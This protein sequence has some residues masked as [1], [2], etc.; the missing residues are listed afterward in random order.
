MGKPLGLGFPRGLA[1]CHTHHV[2]L[3]S[4]LTKGGAFNL[5]L[6]QKFPVKELPLP[7]R[8]PNS[9]ERDGKL[10]KPPPQRRHPRSQAPFAKSRSIFP[11]GRRR[12][13]W[14]GEP[15]G[16]TSERWTLPALRAL[17][18]RGDLALI[19]SRLGS[20]RQEML[21]ASGPRSAFSS[22][23]RPFAGASGA[24]SS[25]SLPCP[26]P[27]TNRETPQRD[28]AER[29]PEL[30]FTCGQGGGERL[31]WPD[32]PPWV[33]SA[34]PSLTQGQAP[35][36]KWQACQSPPF[37]SPMSSSPWPSIGRWPWWLP[38]SMVPGSSSSSFFINSCWT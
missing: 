14:W 33:Q 7:H 27:R 16:L 28:E 37:S 30:P 25:S 31:A 20:G 6:E 10:E 8:S 36:S 5:E 4:S 32:L 24:S 9:I 1:L 2:K 18:S 38:P 13:G 23:P 29:G 34:G 17:G 15:L 11:G 26:S 19:L 12:L 3:P 35:G 21:K 22:T